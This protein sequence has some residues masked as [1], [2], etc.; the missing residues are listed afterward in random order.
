MNLS[1]DV[2]NISPLGWVGKVPTENVHTTVAIVLVA[3]FLI[4]TI[5]GLMG[6]NKRDLE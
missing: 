6:Y 4:L 5:V 3:V 1:D 2:A